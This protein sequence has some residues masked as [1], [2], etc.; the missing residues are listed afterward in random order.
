MPLV[1]RPTVKDSEDLVDFTCPMPREFVDAFNN[2]QAEIEQFRAKLPDGTYIEPI[3]GKLQ[4]ANRQ[5]LLSYARQFKKEEDFEFGSEI[6][7]YLAKHQSK[8]RLTPKQKEIEALK[9]KARATH[10]AAKK[11]QSEGAP[12]VKIQAKIKAYEKLCARIKKLEP[13]SVAA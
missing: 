5:V 1:K 10:A 3:V 2:L 11:L 6:G 4:A 7:A 9:D 13:E 8:P 12:D